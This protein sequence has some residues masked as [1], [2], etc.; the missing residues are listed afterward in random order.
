MLKEDIERVNEQFD[1]E[2][3]NESVMREL[4]QSHIVWL[5]VIQITVLCVLGAW[6]V[7]CLKNFFITK[8][9]VRRSGSVGD[10]LLHGKKPAV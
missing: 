8:K 10:V 3:E 2:K 5:S 4:A 1:A 7:Y 9:I 6:E